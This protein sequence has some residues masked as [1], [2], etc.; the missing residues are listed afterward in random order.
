MQIERRYST[1]GDTTRAANSRVI[2]GH[3]ARFNVITDIGGQFLECVK[4]GAF[5]RSIREGVDT[6]L[7]VNHDPSLI[8]GRV[9]NGSLRL[10]EDSLGLRFRC[11]VIRTR[12]GDDLIECLRTGTLN[13]CSF[14]F[15]VPEG[16]D[17]WS[18]A[19]DAQGNRRHLRE[20]TDVTLMDCSVVTFPQYDGTDAAIQ[21]DD[22]EF[23]SKL[24]TLAA[25]AR[26]SGTPVEL[27][28]AITHTLESSGMSPHERAVLTA[29]LRLETSR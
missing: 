24:A 5:Q 13:R 11:D 23:E 21:E 10:E 12:A 28:S 26:S 6:A 20:L 14:G 2:V 25:V 22:T 18:F 1:R 16:G 27:R 15:T 7:L 8:G 4:P 3:A 29:A 9:S 19:M 17:R